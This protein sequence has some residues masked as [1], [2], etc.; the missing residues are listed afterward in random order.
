MTGPVTR[1]SSARSAAEAECQ[2][3]QRRA[4]QRKQRSAMHQGVLPRSPR[5][6]NLACLCGTCWEWNRRMFGSIVARPARDRRAIRAGR[7]NSRRQRPASV[8]RTG[9][10]SERGIVSSSAPAGM[11][12]AAPSGRDERGRVEL[13]DDRRPGEAVAGAERRAVVDRHVSDPAGEMHRAALD[14]LRAAARAR[15]SAAAARACGRSPRS[16]P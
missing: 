9:A 14:R 3:R 11:H 6:G 1:Y 8:R 4:R 2:E 7:Q 16:G 5:A 12:L 10:R 15:A 13:G